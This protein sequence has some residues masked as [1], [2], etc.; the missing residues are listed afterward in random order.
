M[1]RINIAEFSGEGLVLCNA[2]IKKQLGEKL[3]TKFINR[4][5]V[6]EIPSPG[7]PKHFYLQSILAYELKGSKLTI[8][9]EMG[10][11]LQTLKTTDGLKFITNIIDTRSEPGTIHGELTDIE[12]YPYQEAAISHLVDILA[13]PDPIKRHAYLQMD[14]GLGKTRLGLGLIVEMSTPTVIIV[15]TKAI[16]EQW[17]VEIENNLPTVTCT[18]YNN[19]MGNA[20]HK[21]DIV[22][23]VINT[24]REKSPDFMSY[25]GLMILDEVHEYFSKC[26]K[27]ILWLSQQVSCVL[28]MSATPSSRQD[29]L[30]SYITKFLGEPIRAA[31][32]PGC[33]V[34][35]VKFTGSVKVIKYYG[36]PNCSESV[37]TTAGTT[38][39]IMT[40]SSMVKDKM[41]MKILIDEIME[42]IKVH[43]VM[44]FAELRDYLIEIK[45]ALLLRVAESDIYA[46]ELEILRG[47]SNVHN[48]EHA[49]RSRIV[50]TTYGYS[51]RGV[52]LRD[53]TA[54]VLSTPR[55]SG[56]EQIIGRILRRGS[57]E[58]IERKIIDIVDMNSILKSQ[59]SERKKIYEM[60]SYPITVTKVKFTPVI[61]KDDIILAEP[62]PEP[63][64]FDELY[65]E[66]VSE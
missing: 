49:K 32:I 1:T 29:G 21:Y 37:V 36:D 51:R 7:R 4:M 3:Y 18:I 22:I 19:K 2:T 23:I 14:T 57:D 44:V 50:L 65:D 62:D 10:K 11:Y 45:D 5:T 39:A 48:M 38:S 27:Q 64:N 41:R 59:Y 42:L 20:H 25:F 15:P 53:M 52:S 34:G 24:A 63:D 35:D 28:G 9:A 12:L 8:P 54:L 46:P 17:V 55:K 58:T 60:K 56:M 6:T 47:G 30:D 66:L 43:C 31:T 61:K 26:N 33:S 13:D 16:A 40:I